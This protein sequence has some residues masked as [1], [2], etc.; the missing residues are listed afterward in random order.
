MGEVIQLLPP[1]LPFYVDIERR[2]WLEPGEPYSVDPCLL[3]QLEVDRCDGEYKTRLLTLRG[4]AITIIHTAVLKA[5]EYWSED[6]YRELRPR[7]G[8][9]EVGKPVATPL[10]GCFRLI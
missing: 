8:L 7:R 5:V 2:V 9:I 6:Y 1:E 4:R 3:V 10:P